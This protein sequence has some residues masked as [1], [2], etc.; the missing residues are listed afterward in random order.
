MKNI[1][2]CV[3][4]FALSLLLVAAQSAPASG[5]RA[6]I[7]FEQKC[8]I[9]HSIERAKSKVKT[10]KEWEATVTRMRDD[11]DAPITAEEAQMIVAYLAG[12]YGA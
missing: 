7:L 10:R 6:E 4:G 9:C 3:L 8:S 11:H 1:L 12:H 2:L 5:T